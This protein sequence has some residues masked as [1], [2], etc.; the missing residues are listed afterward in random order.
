MLSTESTIVVIGCDHAAFAL[1]QELGAYLKQRGF[2]LLDV[3]THSEDRCDYPDFAQAACGHIQRGE[4]SWGLLVCG[5]G[6]GMSMAA[7][8]CAGIRAAV[9]SD[10]FSARAT[11]QHNDANVLCMG[12]RVVGLGLAQ[13]ILDAWCSA[14]FE[15]G[16]HQ[17]RIT[18]MMNIN[19]RNT[20]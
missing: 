11:R 15:G 17:E 3:G 9:V 18:K 10:P 4:A 12:S 7:N 6:I 2:I 1:K 5:T 16:R 20:I 13:E 14:S 8:R 19:Q